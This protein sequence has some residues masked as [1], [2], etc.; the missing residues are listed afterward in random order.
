MSEPL[1]LSP[2]GV[3]YSDLRAELTRCREEIAKLRADKERLDWLG[4]SWHCLKLL[5]GGIQVRGINEWQPSIRAAI[6]AARQP[7]DQ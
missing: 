5:K 1:E 6:D 4:R 2:A 7:K 3:G